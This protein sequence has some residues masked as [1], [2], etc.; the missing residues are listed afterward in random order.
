ML[1][2]CWAYSMMA[3]A[4]T[5]VLKNQLAPLDDLDFSEHH[6]AYFYFHRGDDPL[7][8][9]NK[10]NNAIVNEEEKT[11]LVRGGNAVLA[12]MFMSQWGGVID[13][14]LAPLSTSLSEQKAGLDESLAYG[15]EL[16]YMKDALFVPSINI[17]TTKEEKEQTVLLMK[18]LLIEYGALSTSY[19]S[20]VNPT[21]NITYEA[22]NP[23]LY[24]KDNIGAN[25]AVTIVGY[26][27]Y[28]AKEEFHPHQP[29]RDGGWIVKNSWGDFTNSDEGYF[30]IS[31][32]YNLDVTVAFDYMDTSIY[33]NNYFYDGTS[34]LSNYNSS[35]KDDKAVVANVFTSQ[36]EKE[37]LKAVSIGI[38]SSNTDYEI[39]IYKNLQDLNDPTS[40]EAMLKTPTKGSKQISGI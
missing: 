32:D 31:Y 2:L 3:T 35:S 23:Y 25:H 12:S 36:K 5:S 11:Y 17:T 4:E 22:E 10:D 39:Q 37:Y 24:V 38:K 13:D 21:T 9:T 34:T 40:G 19:N 27:D 8:L 26:N 30:Y 14:D 28:I 29:S 16:F 20:L 33:D 1:G 15:N 6:L 18:Q 7:N